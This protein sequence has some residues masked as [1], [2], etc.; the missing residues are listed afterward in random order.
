MLGGKELVTI[1]K[2][3]QRHWLA[4]QSMDDMPVLDDMTVLAVGL[5]TPPTQ[6]HELC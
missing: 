4:L 5:R 3:Q 2:M 1:N 6:R